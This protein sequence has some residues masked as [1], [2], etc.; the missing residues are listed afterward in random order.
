MRTSLHNLWIDETNAAEWSDSCH[1]EVANWFGVLGGN[2]GHTENPL[3]SLVAPSKDEAKGAFV[4]N[5]DLDGHF[6]CRRG[7][8]IV[9]LRLPM[10]FHGVF[11]SHRQKFQE[12][13]VSVWGSWLGEAPGFRV[14]RPTSLARREKVEW[15]VG[16]PGGSYLGAPLHELKNGEKEKL[17]RQKM[18]LIGSP[19]VYPP[20]LREVLGVYGP[21]G[22]GMKDGKSSAKTWLDVHAAVLAN[23]EQMPEATDEDDLQHRILVTFPVWLKHRISNELLRALL[24]SNSELSSRVL[25]TLRDGLPGNEQLAQDAWQ[26][27]RSALILNK[28]RRRS[29]DRDTW[30]AISP[31]ENQIVRRIAGAIQSNNSATK[32]DFID[33]IN[34][35][36]LVSRITRVRRLHRP[37]SNT[38][39]IPAEY[40]Q[41]HPSFRGRLCP[42]ESPE[43]E[44]VGLSVQLAAGATVDFEGRIHPSTRPDEELGF[45]AALIPFFA[46]NDGARNMMGAKNLRQAVPLMKRQRPA[47]ETGGEGRVQSFAAPLLEIGLCSEA[48]TPEGDFAQGKD[49]LVAYLPWEGLNFEDAIVLG[50]QVVEQELLDVALRKRISKRIKPGWFPTE[51][52]EQTALSWG[53]DGL[54][55]EGELLFA[56]SIIAS[57]AWEGKAD[58]KRMEIRHDDRTPAVLKKIEFKRRSE[59]SGGVLEY[60][61]ELSLPVRPGDKLMG[62]HGNKGVVGA[63]VPSDQMP[64]LPDS[65]KLPIHLRGRQ[66]D[67]LLNP[68][69]VISRMNLGQ[70]IETHIGWLL[71]SK[72][73]QQQELVKAGTPDGLP[74]GQAFADVLDHE[75]V[76]SLLEKT[77]LDRHGRIRLQ[78]PDGSQTVSPVTVGFQHIVRLRHVPQLKSQARRGGQG[79]LYSMRTGQAIHGRKLGGGQRLGEMEVWALAAHQ[80][81]HVLAEFLG[82]KSSADLVSQLKSGHPRPDSDGD[83]GYRRVL[84]DWLFA[85][86]INLDLTDEQVRFSFSDADI[87]L[88]RIGKSNRVL[89]GNRLTLLTT[90]RFCCAAKG[91]KHPCGFTMFDGVSIAVP[92]PK[93]DKSGQ[94]RPVRLPLGSLLDQLGLCATGRLEKLD[95]VHLLTLHNRKTEQGDGSIHFD[96]EASTDQLKAVVRPMANDSPSTWP[97]DLQEVTL[98]GRFDR[99]K[100]MGGGNFLGVELVEEFIKADG[101]RSITEMDVTC[102]VHRTVKLKGE[103]PF[104][105]MLWGV[106]GG[107]FDPKIFGSLTSGLEGGTPDRWGYI[108]LPEPIPYPLHLFLTPSHSSRDQKGAVESFCRI[109]GVDAGKIPPIRHVPVLPTRFRMPTKRDGKLE[110]DE[111]E[112]RGYGPLADACRRHAEARSEKTKS[113]TTGEI[114]QRM[115]NLFALLIDALRDKTG[116]IRRHGLGRRVDRSARLVVIP[117]PSLQWDQA[118]IPTA[119]LVELIG[120]MVTQRQGSTQTGKESPCTDI[121]WLHPKD[122]PQALEQ[123]RVQI[124]SF[125]ESHPDFVVL[126]NRQPSLHR[127]SFQAFHPVPLPT[128]A[129]DVIQLCPLSCAGF[130]A[131][132]DGDEMVIHVPL[133]DLAQKEAAKLLPSRNLFSQATGK[134]LA[135]FDQDFV[136]GTYWLGEEDAAGLHGLFLDLLPE[137]C[138]RLLIKGQRRITKGDAEKII[139]HLCVKHRARV[140]ELIWSWMNLAFRACSRVGV[141]F[142]FYELRDT[143]G[144]LAAEVGKLDTE[145]RF[146]DPNPLLEN[147]ASSA[148]QQ[149]VQSG[150]DLTKPGLHFA[151]MFI[152]GAR[153]GPK[154]IRQIVAARGELAPGVVG[155]NVNPVNF[156]VSRSLVDGLKPEDAFW[157]AMNARSSLCDK[158]LGTGHA[159]ALTRELVFAL[160]PFKIV[161]RDCGAVSIPRSV[162]TCQEKGGFCAACYGLLP[163]GH[164]PSTGFPAGLIA[165]QSIGERGTQLSMQS[166][167]ASASQF[168]IR[169]VR[170]IL[171]NEKAMFES[172]ASSA[173]F[174]TKML[175]CDEYSRLKPRHFDVLWRAIF[176]SPKKTLKSAIDSRE[177]L[178]RLAFQNQAQLT[179]LAAMRNFTGSRKDPIAQVLFAGFGNERAVESTAHVS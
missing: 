77:G 63:I 85:L 69:G 95:G 11:L 30:Q 140:P 50:Q 169:E 18:R 106:Q 134:L 44:L 133:G 91:K 48:V 58:G 28:R 88:T 101:V 136:M 117:N 150:T 22:A 166:V 60:E 78:L 5:T 139:T 118:G 29:D 82:V 7:D 164:A 14:V 129:G 115:E 108:E 4:R 66:I 163:D 80:A 46:H 131:D 10:S 154:P 34:P 25:A 13:L 123:A 37:S 94:N 176:D 168:S 172:P 41:N 99:G 138:C 122:D 9:E 109:N 146:E 31:F 75:K 157:A 100:E 158:K 49:L 83:V 170:R 36:D 165:A 177:L 92:P 19:A 98:Y 127:D 53:K 32:T 42:V 86:L 128:A 71:H 87:T 84:K 153:G 144:R 130:G 24:H 45:G 57:L 12:A 112:R 162:V 135:H 156:Y 161:S 90:A 8:E 110:P 159:G 38:D 174:V 3:F 151:A 114:Q 171:A 89:F 147:I 96:F 149:V 148:L 173:A 97:K 152:S 65:D 132:F 143:A 104:G 105:E 137:D 124:H 113:A 145:K 47:V 121:S 16:L 55:K 23:L 81:E 155:F 61:L 2:S 72:T 103:K 167:R 6:Y 179:A 70:L 93:Q 1:K 126:L 102:P 74:I 33:P 52:A 141:S 21:R 27:M 59:W 56:G 125:L 15:R 64:R 79:A 20:W 43:S 17:S 111:I 142:G 73:C 40:R 54:A 51:P 160:W 62:R 116:L 120:D 76:Q 39:E 175:K 67:V 68:H 107:L 178:A 119:V 26:A 35:L